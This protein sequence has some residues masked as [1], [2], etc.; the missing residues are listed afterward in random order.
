MEPHE[1]LSRTMIL[2]RHER[3]Q[4][5]EDVQQDDQG[6]CGEVSHVSLDTSMYQRT[7]AKGVVENDACERVEAASAKGGRRRT[8]RVRYDRFVTSID[9]KRR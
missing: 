6:R 3:T 8:I 9:V 5:D 7:E 4:C 2:T 1:L